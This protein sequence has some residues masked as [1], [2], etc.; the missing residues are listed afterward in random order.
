MNRR[1]INEIVSIYSHLI[2]LAEKN[3]DETI[4]MEWGKWTPTESMLDILTSRRDK[5]KSGKFNILKINKG[6]N[7]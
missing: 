7:K 6:E 3:I 5:L 4:I 2:K 1:N